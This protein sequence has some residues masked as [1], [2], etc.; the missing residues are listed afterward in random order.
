MDV[1]EIMATKGNKWNVTENTKFG[2]LSR[3]QLAF[4]MPG[5]KQDHKKIQGQLGARPCQ[6][7]NYRIRHSSQE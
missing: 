2:H 5:K 7:E 1:T 3:T 6:H 4:T